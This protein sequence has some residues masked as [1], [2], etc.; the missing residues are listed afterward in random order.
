MTDDSQITRLRNYTITKLTP[1]VARSAL[2][3]MPLKREFNE[4]IDEFWILQSRGCPQLGIHADGGEAGHG[5]D[6][7]HVKLVI[8][9]IEQEIHA[10]QP[11]T[12]YRLKCRDCHLLH[13]PC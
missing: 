9:R 1:A 11:G 6:L 10:R 7:I 2:L 5:I 13:L 4:S 8:V 3:L 12:I